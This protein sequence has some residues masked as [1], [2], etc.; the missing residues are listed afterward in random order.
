VID[1]IQKGN[2]A[3]LSG[4][5]RPFLPGKGERRVFDEQGKGGRE[6]HSPIFL[7]ER[8]KKVLHP[9]PGKEAM[10]ESYLRE[11]SNDY[12]LERAARS[13]KR[14]APRWEKSNNSLSSSKIGG[15][16]EGQTSCDYTGAETDGEKKGTSDELIG[17]GEIRGNYFGWEGKRNV[18]AFT[19]LG[20]GD[21]W[22]RKDE[23]QRTSEREKGYGD[24]I[25]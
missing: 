15:K 11:G 22:Q 1:A 5:S 7:R 2:H 23:S 24:I 3:L 4:E 21:H 12:L 25:T 8:R 16:K 10:K 6:R 20:K 17:E 14:R 19:H 18:D 13:Q 9:E